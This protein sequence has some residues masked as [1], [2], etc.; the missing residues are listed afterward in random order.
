MKY[1]RLYT[2]PDGLS[3]FQD[4][5]IP[6]DGGKSGQHLSKL[7][8]ATGVIF[9]VTGADYDYDW[10][11]APRRQFVVNLEGSVEIVASDGTTRR[12][13]P[14]EIMLAEDTTG[15]GHISRA[16]NNQPRNSLFIA[17]D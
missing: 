6:L 3:H 1:T 11:N 17:L 2:G 7:I 8:K 16:V 4:V 10:H 15:K 12:L 14:G 9:R 13:G 5:E